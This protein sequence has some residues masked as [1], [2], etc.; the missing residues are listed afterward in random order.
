[1]Y[2][3]DP[4]R[5]V[6]TEGNSAVIDITPL[7]EESGDPIKLQNGDKILFTIKTNLGKTKLQKV[8]TNENYDGEE[9]T[10]IDCVINPEE[11]LGWS[12]GEY[13]YDCVLITY[14]N[15]VFTFIS[16]TLHIDTAYGKFTDLEG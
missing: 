7:D 12:A 14:D 5:I 15:Q 6:M 16:S 10:S 2:K 11:T 9:D 1:M 13:L 4:N 8:L 3:L